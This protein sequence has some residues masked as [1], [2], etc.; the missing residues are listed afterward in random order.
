MKIDKLTN[1]IIERWTGNS[2]DTDFGNLT[3]KEA[4]EIRNPEW[5]F[6]WQEELRI[7]GIKVKKMFIV[8]QPD[9]IVGLIS[10]R[11]YPKRYVYVNNIEKPS[12]RT[13]K[14]Y[15][16]I[17]G[18]L[19]AYACKISKQNGANGRIVFEAKDDIIEHYKKEL[20]AKIQKN[21]VMYIENDIANDLITRYFKI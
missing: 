14:D 17:A 2:V 16:G 7:K 5:R 21:N 8:K 13:N 18:N 12:Y 11:I 10:Y 15:I 20:G 4:E 19:M 1:S 9:N 3:E 6:D